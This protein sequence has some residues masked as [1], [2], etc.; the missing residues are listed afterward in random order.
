MVQIGPDGILTY[1][2]QVRFW[3]QDPL[4]KDYG[5]IHVSHRTAFGRDDVQ[6]DDQGDITAMPA[7]HKKPCFGII[8]AVLR[9]Y[10]SS[11]GTFWA[12]GKPMLTRCGRCPIRGVCKTVVFTRI[13]SDPELTKAVLAWRDAGRDNFGKEWS[14]LVDAVVKRGPFASVNDDLIRRSY[15]PQAERRRIADAARKKAKR[16]ADRPFDGFRVDEDYFAFKAERLRRYERLTAAVAHPEAPFN[17]AGLDREQIS[18]TVACWEAAFLRARAIKSVTPYTLA[19]WFHMRRRFTDRRRRD[20]AVELRSCLKR[21]ESLE[22]M[23][24]PGSKDEKLW[25]KFSLPLR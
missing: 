1:E 22:N 12:N 25:G 13:K 14:L 11:V 17:I 20:L 7:L 10:K 16:A 18:L 15:S 21:I 6:I 5:Q 19:T 2:E 3:A 4:P 24:M 23:L 9:H 8:T